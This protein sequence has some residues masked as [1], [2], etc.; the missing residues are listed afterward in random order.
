MAMG[1]RPKL[2]A[3]DGARIAIEIADGRAQDPQRA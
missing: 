1:H 2:L 3:V